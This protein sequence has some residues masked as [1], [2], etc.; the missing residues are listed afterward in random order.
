[1]IKAKR[2]IKNKDIIIPIIGEDCFFYKNSVPLQSFIVDELAE[3]KNV[4]PSLLEKMKTRGY[5]G[6]TL[7]KKHFFERENDFSDEYESVIED[8][9]ADI[10]LEPTVK[11]FLD[12]FEFPMIIT[13]SCFK[14]IEEK[15]STDYQS[16]AYVSEEVNRSKINESEKI[17]Y[18]IFGMSEAGRDY[19]SD[20]NKLL[21]FLHELHGKEGAKDLKEY[22]NS[23]RKKALFIIGSN[24]PDWLFRFF[25]YPIKGIKENQNG[26]FI[27]STEK[28]EDS[29]ENFLESLSYDYAE[30]EKLTSILSEAI[31]IYTSFKKEDTG[32]RILHGKKYDIF[33]SYASE[34]IE[35]VRNIKNK[36]VEKYKLNVWFD[37]THI[38]DGNYVDRIKNGIENSAYFMPIVTKEYVKKHKIVDPPKDKDS[39]F[40]NKDLE[41]VQMETLY[42]SFVMEANSNRKVYS[43]PV[44]KNDAVGYGKKLN[45][46]IVES[47]FVGNQLPPVLFEHQQMFDLD[48]M[49]VDGNVDWNRYKTIEQ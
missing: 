13:T 30:K 41:F 24:L 43:L 3:G 21:S 32:G 29:L 17:V 12:T 10:D 2:I 11:K 45:P 39:V 23:A 27:N 42:A 46:A 48:K 6:L 40:E 5:Y 19:V 1:M 35:D 16:L 20:E 33:I 47:Q 49:F 38:K 15:L 26:F 36:L 4:E 8:N 28:M 25:L 34:N 31:E 9:F 14:L 37:E 44:V 22:I 7:L 18:H